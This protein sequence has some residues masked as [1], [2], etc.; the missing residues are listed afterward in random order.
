M[1]EQHLFNIFFE[2]EQF[3]LKYWEIRTIYIFFPF[4]IMFDLP[5]YLFS[6]VVTF[7]V[8][9]RKETAKSIQ[10][11]NEGKKW[12]FETQPLVS[13]I[14][15][16]LNEE[17]TILHTVKSLQEQTYN[18]LEIIVCDDC[19][20]DKTFE[21]CLP[22]ARAGEIKVVRSSQRGG[23]S[24][25]LNHALQFVT[26]DIVVG[27]DSDTLF[28]RDALENL[29]F[30]FKNPEV[31]AVGGNLR[32][33]NAGVNI[34]TSLQSMEYLM[35]ISTG[36]R[37][38]SDIDTLYIISGAFGS[39]RAN[40]LKSVKGYSQ[41][42]GEDS[43]IT[44]KMRKKNYRIRFAHKAI[45]YTKVPTSLYVIFKQRFRWNTSL[46]KVKLRKHSN[47]INP[48]WD[49][50]TLS[51]FIGWFDLIFFQLILTTTF[52]LFVFLFMTHKFYTFLTVFIIF[53]FISTVVRTIE[54]LIAWAL[55]G[56][57]KE[58]L[59]LLLY[60]PL[61]GV[62]KGYII[63]LVRAIA[64]FSELFFRVSYKLPFV[65]DRVRKKAERW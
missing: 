34:I 14:V 47:I 37:F 21:I 53:Q 10:F 17:E 39:Y 11:E 24:S 3:F 8:A 49:T 12:L 55:N 60:V 43:D 35:S 57:R 26:G 44:T 64:Y 15:P 28:Q 56:K 9:P 30:H 38:R 41:G 2:I 52:V 16:A 42:P 13:V 46:I 61:F 45:C 25:A 32:V 36:R 59:A 23:K 22:L 33:L 27:I 54:L 58:D 50:F 18:N 5:R 1:L 29:L 4:F 7:V 65:P 6:R 40:L 63:R 19:S 51:N 20:T 62:Y 31:G 48:D